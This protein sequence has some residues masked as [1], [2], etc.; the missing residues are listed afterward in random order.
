MFLQVNLHKMEYPLNFKKEDTECNR[1]CKGNTFHLIFKYVKLKFVT[2]SEEQIFYGH[3]VP[4]KTTDILLY[5]K[6]KN[7]FK[8]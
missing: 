4:V 1:E 3:R 8:L 6:T 2:C 7:V 5:S